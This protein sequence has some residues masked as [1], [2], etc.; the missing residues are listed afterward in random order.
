MKVKDFLEVI[1]SAIYDY[2][3]SDECGNEIFRFTEQELDKV[4]EKVLNCEVSSIELFDSFWVITVK[5]E[6][7]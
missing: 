6:M 1:H 5:T 3:V 7:V 4:P 2:S